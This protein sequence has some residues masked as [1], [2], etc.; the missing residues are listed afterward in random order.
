MALLG[1]K[2]IPNLIPFLECHKA[3]LLAHPNSFP[4]I[5]S[6]NIIHINSWHRLLAYKDFLHRI[7][8]ISDR[9]FFILTFKNLVANELVNIKLNAP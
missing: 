8:H 5:N 1:N 2:I 4:F 7:E 9:G 3:Q 6:N